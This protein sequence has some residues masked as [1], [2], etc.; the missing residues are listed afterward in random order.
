[1][2][3]NRLENLEDQAFQNF[4]E[5]TRPHSYR[6]GGEIAESAG[7]VQIFVDSTKSPSL[8]V[9]GGRGWLATLGSKEAVLANLADLGQIAARM[10]T[11]GE[12]PYH[13]NAQDEA[14][15]MRLSALPAEVR[16]AVISKRPLV[17]ETPCGLYTLVRDEFTPVNDGPPIDRIREDEISLVSSL[18]QHGERDA[19]IAERIARAPHVAVRVGDELAAYMLVHA[20]GSIGMLHTI[21]KF[22]N[23]KLGRAAASALAAMQ[24]ARGMPVY[25]YII[26][27]NTPSQRVFTSLGFRRVADVS[28]SVFGKEN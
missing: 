1:M 17:R 27:G 18:G 13:P 9:H 14:G 7:E 24:M 21:E 5:S 12:K 10:E 15:V 2:A 20:N 22:R 16:E 11:A 3:L 8:C 25:C 23:Q 26:D 19:Y 6:M 28:W 4:L